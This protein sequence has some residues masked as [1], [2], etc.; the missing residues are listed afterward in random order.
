MPIKNTKKLIGIKS[1]ASISSFSTKFILGINFIIPKPLV[2]VLFYFYQYMVI[3]NN[4]NKN[5]TILSKLVV[6]FNQISI[7]APWMCF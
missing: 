3:S 2:I 5:T 6:G 1:I 7:L 4:F